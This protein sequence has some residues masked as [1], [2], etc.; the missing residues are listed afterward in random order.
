MESNVRIRYQ[1]GIEALKNKINQL[2]EVYPTGVG[3]QD[4]VDPSAL[5]FPMSGS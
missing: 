5:T 2:V 3:E 4:T 1:N